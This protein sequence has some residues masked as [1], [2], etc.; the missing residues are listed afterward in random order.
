MAAKKISSKERPATLTIAGHQFQ[1]SALIDELFQ[2]MKD[3]H[4]IHL[5]RLAGEEVWTEDP[6]LQEFKFTN[7]FRVFDRNTQ[8][9]LREVIPKGPCDDTEVCF[10]VIL[11]RMFNRIETWELLTRRL[12][13]LTWKE[14]DA[15]QYDVV[16][17][18]VAAVHGHAYFIPAPR[19]GGDDNISNHLRLIFLLMSLQVVSHLKEFRHMQDAVEYI[20][21]FPG[22]GK[23]TGFQ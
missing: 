23:F 17:R 2:F 10:R 12:G 21:L 9:I 13:Q 5:R 6:I 4:D 20:C 11:F 8:F 15:E 14:F 18:S 3:R 22:M 7:I 19:L 16:L 1:V